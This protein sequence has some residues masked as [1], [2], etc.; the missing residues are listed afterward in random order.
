MSQFGE[1]GRTTHLKFFSEYN[2]KL[3]A[4]GQNCFGNNAYSRF[5]LGS[6]LPMTQMQFYPD[7]FLTRDDRSDQV[8]E[9]F[10][11]FSK[12]CS[13]PRR[14]PRFCIGLLR[15]CRLPPKIPCFFYVMPLV[16]PEMQR[17]KRYKLCPAP[18]GA[19]LGHTASA[20]PPTGWL[21]N[22]AKTGNA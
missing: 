17:G 3:I 14:L 22:S 6:V 5:Y 20:P 7:S 8:T 2:R 1:G 21:S 19:K 10:D 4:S 15:C 18:L 11:Y 12:S 13:A 16:Q 9:L